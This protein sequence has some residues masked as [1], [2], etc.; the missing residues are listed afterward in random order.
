MTFSPVELYDV[1]FINRGK[2]QFDLPEGYNAMVLITE[3]ETIVSGKA[4]ENGDMLYLS[5]EGTEMEIESG[6]RAKILIMAGKPLDEEVAAYG[7]FVMNTEEEIRQAFE[8]FRNGK[9][10]SIG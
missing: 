6:D 1:R 5:Q 4:L 8:D 2:V 9:M 7:P 10:G 3:G